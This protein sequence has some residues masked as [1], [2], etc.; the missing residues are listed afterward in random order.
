MINKFIIEVLTKEGVK[1]VYRS[2]GIDFYFDTEIE[3]TTKLNEI[4]SN[5]L[6]IDGTKHSVINLTDLPTVWICGYDSF[7]ESELQIIGIFNEM[8]SAAS[9]RDRKGTGVG[10]FI[11]EAPLDYYR[12]NE[13]F[14]KLYSPSDDDD[15]LENCADVSLRQTTYY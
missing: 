8:K 1:S 6:N 5:E 9:E 15:Y 4:P 14:I 3:A 11:T 2:E 12:G 13:I 7:G 10:Y